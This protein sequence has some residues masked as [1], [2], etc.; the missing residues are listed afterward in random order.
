MLVPARALPRALLI[1]Q[2]VHFLLLYD[3]DLDLI[4][5]ICADFRVDVWIPF[6]RKSLAGIEMLYLR[7][8]W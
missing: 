7:T 4:D 1:P 5:S 8:I 6:H 2:P 3:Y